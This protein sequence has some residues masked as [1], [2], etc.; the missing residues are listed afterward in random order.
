[1]TRVLV[2]LAAALTL[3]LQ[4][5]AAAAAEKVAPAS[6]ATFH[7]T[8]ELQGIRFS[9]TSANDSSINTLRIVPAGLEIDNSPI[10]LTIDGTVTGAEVADINA[11]GSPEIYVFVA[12]A[13]SGSYGSLA[14]F[15]ANRRKSL[16]T[17]YLPPI[18]EDQPLARGYMGH[19]VF[20]LAGNALLRRFPVYRE[21]DSNANP[22]GGARELR[23]KLVAGEAG[24]LLKLDQVI[25]LK[26]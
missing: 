2:A 25:E 8:L 22:T 18:T 6:G 5:E 17:I 4:P 11:D 10:E 12:S 7:R 26:P 23:Y 1:M 13:G 24:W 14:A 15:S 9:V 20:A 16:S 21:D 3:L 19:D